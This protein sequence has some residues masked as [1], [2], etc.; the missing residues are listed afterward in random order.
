MHQATALL[1]CQLSFSH[2]SPTLHSASFR[3]QLYD[4]LEIFNIGGDLPYTNYLFLGDYVDRGHFSVETISLLACLKLRWPDRVVLLRGNHESRQI[5]QVRMRGI[6]L[7]FS[8]SLRPSSHFRE[9]V[10]GFVCVMFGSGCNPFACSFEA[11]R[12]NLSCH[13]MTAH[14]GAFLHV[15][16]EASG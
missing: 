13:T 10:A 2:F 4:V 3:R 7:S 1:H 5:T 8:P 11:L 15:M 6:V 9:L 16:A 14:I 12:K